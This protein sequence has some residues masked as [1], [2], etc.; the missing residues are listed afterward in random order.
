VIA[1][2]IFFFALIALIVFGMWIN[3]SLGPLDLN[4]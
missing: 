4:R 2:L 3:G 1:G